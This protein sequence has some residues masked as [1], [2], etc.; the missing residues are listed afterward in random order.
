MRSSPT[1]EIGGSW[2]T[3][4]PTPFWVGDAPLVQLEV[5]DGGVP[6]VSLEILDSS[7]QPLL[8]ITE[9]ELELSG[10]RDGALDVRMG[11]HRTTVF[12]RAQQSVV[13]DLSIETATR[14]PLP[15]LLVMGQRENSV[16]DLGNDQP[17]PVELS[18]S[19]VT[20]DPWGAIIAHPDQIVLGDVEAARKSGFEKLAFATTYEGAVGLSLPRAGPND[21]TVAVS[22]APGFAIRQCGFWGF[23]RAVQINPALDAL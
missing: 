18:L 2:F 7:F 15:S 19:F 9:N 17:G 21:R 4:V 20:Y 10:V 22:E 6:L 14:P 12:D 1:V 23:A 3:D 5:G 8:R 16:L 11:G 13:L